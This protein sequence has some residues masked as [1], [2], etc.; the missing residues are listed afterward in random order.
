[1]KLMR[2]AGVQPGWSWERAMRATIQDPQYRAIKEPNDRRAAFERYQDQVVKEDI[3]REKERV[4]KLRTDFR[5]MLASHPEIKHYTRWKT[6]RSI[7]EGETIFRATDNEDE[8][9]RLFDEYIQDQKRIAEEKR[10]Q[11]YDAAIA[12]LSVI[13]KSLNL[14]AKSQWV[15]T[16]EQLQAHPEFSS[17]E[18]YRLIAPTEPL[19]IFERHMRR[20]WNDA[21]HEK[22]RSAHSKAREQR[23]ARDQFVELLKELRE[24]DKIKPGSM[25]KEIFPLVENDPR[26]LGLLDN[27]GNKDRNTDGSTPLDLFFDMLEDLDREVHDVRGLIEAILKVYTCFAHSKNHSMLT[28]MS[29]ISI[30]ALPPPQPLMSTWTWSS[31]IDAPPPSRWISWKKCTNA[32]SEVLSIVKRTLNA[33]PSASRKRPSMPFVPG[34]NISILL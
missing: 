10:Q 20:L 19:H 22:Q 30:S 28:N 14:T 2:K 11:D 13:L 33:T 1:M 5:A 24:A 27:L 18:K 21:H 6:A 8:K 31:V 32:W 23:K 12:G 34:S 9:R 4:K 29:R 3:E 26:Y 17:D 25:W 16:R 7:V 15:E